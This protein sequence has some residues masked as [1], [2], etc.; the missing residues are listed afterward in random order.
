MSSI[1]RT[2]EETTNNNNN[3]PH[4]NVNNSN[5]KKQQYSSLLMHENYAT[6]KRLVLATLILFFNDAFGDPAVV[7]IWITVST[8]VNTWALLITS[9]NNNIIPA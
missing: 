7:L 4:H 6:A 9:H 1:K 5:V 8:Y 3:T 2:A